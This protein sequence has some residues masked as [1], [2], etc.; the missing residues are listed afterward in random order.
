MRAVETVAAVNSDHTMTA[1]LPADIPPGSHRVVVVIEAD[2]S[3][4]PPPQHGWANWPAHDVAL[5]DPT[6][7][8]RRED[9]YGD[10]GR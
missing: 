4:E 6:F 1:Q 7:T 9:L 10:D 5:T 2:T 8:F 3:H